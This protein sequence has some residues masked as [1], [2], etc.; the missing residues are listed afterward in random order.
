[1]WLNILLPILLLPLTSSLLGPQ[2]AAGRKSPSLFSTA[3][4]PWRSDSSVIDSITNRIVTTLIP[5][6]RTDSVVFEA[7][8]PLHSMNVSQWEL[9]WDKSIVEGRELVYMNAL[10]DQLNMIKSLGMECIA[11]EERFLYQASSVKPARIGNMCFR[12]D[13]FRKVR[14]T[15]FDGGENVQVRPRAIS[16]LLPGWDMFKFTRR[17]PRRFIPR[18]AVSICLLSSCHRPTT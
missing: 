16:I 2:Q 8:A 7:G 12:G 13:R 14:L 1:M 15:Y 18:T 9:P 17:T 4:F 11:L 10:K 6:K 5:Q 3:P